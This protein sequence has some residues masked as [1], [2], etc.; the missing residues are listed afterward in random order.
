[1]MS[2]FEIE[3]GDLCFLSSFG[4]PLVVSGE[5]F[6][7]GERGSVSMFV[8]V[9]RVWYVFE[10]EAEWRGIAFFGATLLGGRRIS[11]L[12][13]CFPSVLYYPFFCS[14]SRLTGSASLNL[15][16]GTKKRATSS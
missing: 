14:H 7:R 13:L 12:C 16:G 10:A 1:M 8:A 15:I 5:G 11:S 4:K 3:S 6:F 9:V 2:K